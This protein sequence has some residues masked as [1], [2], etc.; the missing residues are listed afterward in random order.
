MWNDGT[1][2]GEY[3]YSVKGKVNIVD[4]CLS[5]GGTRPNVVTFVFSCSGLG[6]PENMNFS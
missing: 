2:E 6:S 4:Q 5:I 1:R 3:T